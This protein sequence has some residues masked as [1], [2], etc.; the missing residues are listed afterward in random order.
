MQ[1][2]GAAV[3]LGALAG[4]GDDEEIR[5]QLDDVLHRDKAAEGDAKL[6]GGA[7]ETSLSED[8][9]HKTVLAGDPAAARQRQHA[10]MLPRR[11]LLRAGDGR[12][13]P[14]DLGGGALGMTG[15]IAHLADLLTHVSERPRDREFDEVLAI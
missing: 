12:I 1:Q 4:I 11:R 6:A 7:D 13:Q 5:L 3:I 14:R 9:A 15:E 10:E 8:R 2:E